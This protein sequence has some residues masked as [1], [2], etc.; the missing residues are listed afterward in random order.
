MTYSCLVPGDSAVS[1]TGAVP[2]L[3]GFLLLSLLSLFYLF[4]YMREGRGRDTRQVDRKNNF[5]VVNPIK[6]MIE[7]LRLG[8]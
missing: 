5:R 4:I 6:E 1:G 2:A 7:F 3:E 8:A